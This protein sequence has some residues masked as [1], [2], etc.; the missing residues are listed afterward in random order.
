VWTRHVAKERRPTDDGVHRH[1]GF[2]R[3][4]LANLS[5]ETGGQFAVLALSVTAV[6]VLDASALQVGILTALGHAAYLVLGIP[7]G[8]WVDGWRKRPVLVA[9]DLVRA[10]AVVTVPLAHW[11][12]ALTIEHLMA[13]AAIVSAAAVFSD[14]AHTAILPPLVGRARVAEANARL[15]TTDSTMRVV[16][17]S[18]AGAL[19]TRVAAPVLYVFTAVTAAASALLSASVRLE[20]PRLP[21]REREPLS[22]SVRAGLGFVVHHPALR[23]YMLASATNN[24]AAGMFMAVAS[25]FVLRDLD[26][27]PT[28]YAVAGAV[29][30]TGG[31]LGSVAGLRIRRRLGEIRTIVTCCHLRPLAFLVLPAAV[32]VPVPAVVLLAVSDFAFGFVT[33]VNSISSTGMRA[34]VTPHHLMARVA[35]ASRFVSLGTIPL[36]AV[37]GGALAGVLP[38]AG[39]L[40]AAAVVAALAIPVLLAS[41]LRPHRD[42]PRE[43]EE[44]AAR[45]DQVASK[46]SSTRS[47]KASGISSGM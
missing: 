1:P 4:W 42:V 38:R 23:T 35:S 5:N 16:G 6:V 22:R 45:A 12:G 30:A 32:V 13:V 26:M 41:P 27:D 2:R 25:V 34:R 39:V 7:V 9:A 21:R 3:L 31:I 18:L 10:V 40:V 44:E 24:L 43:W 8:A 11:A 37:L 46:N 15:Q 14:T 19:L 33:V 47:R 17:P 36:G 20:E 28:A 29:G